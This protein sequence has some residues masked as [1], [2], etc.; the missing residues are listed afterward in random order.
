MHSLLSPAPNGEGELLVKWPSFSDTGI[1][2]LVFGP[3]VLHP[4]LGQ[5]V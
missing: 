4:A 1:P 3:V 2:P 5:T